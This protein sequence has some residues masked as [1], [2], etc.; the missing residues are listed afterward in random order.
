M[1]VSPTMRLYRER[2][3]AGASAVANPGKIPHEG[4][5]VRLAEVQRFAGLER[6]AREAVERAERALL[7]AQDT[8]AKAAA[9]A[10]RAN[11]K[12]PGPVNGQK[13]EKDLEGA[14]R[15]RAVTERAAADA[16]GELLA[17]LGEH[18]A[19][20][21]AEVRRRDID[22]LERARTL[23]GEA[24]AELAARSRELVL[25]RWVDD[26]HQAGRGARSP[27]EVACAAALAR[28]EEGLVEAAKPAVE[29]GPSEWAL[30]QAHNAKIDKRAKQLQAEGS[31]ETAAREAAWHEV[32]DAA[33]AVREAETGRREPRRIPRDAAIQETRRS[34]PQT[35]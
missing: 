1:S 18:R 10:L 34:F 9:D 23:I 6:D 11:G 28:V 26:P 16:H 4:V 14:H 22:R 29:P 24:Q 31:G 17:A 21:K 3:P 5:A 2:H 8:D 7:R 25:D 33:R 15:Q 19:E 32:N 35:A 27:V 12:D 20:L 13:A 30:L